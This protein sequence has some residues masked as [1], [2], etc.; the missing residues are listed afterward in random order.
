MS[1]MNIQQTIQSACNTVLDYVHQNMPD[2]AVFEDT[3]LQNSSNGVKSSGIYSWTKAITGTPS[4]S[5]TLQQ[6]VEELQLAM[7]NESNAR[8]NSDSI[9]SGRISTNTNDISTT[10]TVLSGIETRVSSVESSLS[11]KQNTLTNGNGILLSGS[12]IATDMGSVSAGVTKPVSGG[13]VHTAI[14]NATA[15]VTQGSGITV[16]VSGNNKV[17]STNITY[18]TP[19]KKENAQSGTSQTVSIDLDNAPTENST[20]MVNSGAI[21]TALNGKQNT[22]TAGSGIDITNN[23]ISAILPTSNPN[24]NGV[25]W[26]ELS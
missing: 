10:N 15:N 21:Y 12:Y 20:K 7:T 14:T 3:V 23:T 8:S 16:S 25:L 6:E 26:L 11:G 18:S 17:V 19:L 5:K 9:L 22:L 1:E 13:D 2:G 24:V 4:D